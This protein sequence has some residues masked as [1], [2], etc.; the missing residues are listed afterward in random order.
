[1][2]AGGTKALATEPLFSNLGGYPIDVAVEGSSGALPG[3]IWV[4]NLRLNVIDVFEPSDYGG[5]PAPPCSGADSP[6]LDEDNDNYSNTDEIANGT[7][8]CSGADVPHDWDRDFVSDLR[9]PDDDNDG[10]P[11][12]SDPFPVDAANGLTTDVP[13]GYPFESGAS[14]SPCAPTPVPSG[15]PGGIIGLGFTGLMTNG[16]TDYGANF[17]PSR[18]TVGGA[19]GVLTVDALRPATRSAR[20]TINSTRSSTACVCRTRS[21]RCIRR[22]SHR[23]R[24]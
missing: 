10:R 12:V 1:M 6:A 17:D 18:M 2:D 13:I 5:R 20:R 8:P 15:C 21:S 23:S 9:D 7:D 22:C 3:T 19:G 16:S 14:A 24:V 4:P 11:D